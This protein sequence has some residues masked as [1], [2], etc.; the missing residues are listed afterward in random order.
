MGTLIANTLF[1]FTKEKNTFKRIYKNG[2][3]HGMF[4]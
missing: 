1:H 4:L 3:S 2:I